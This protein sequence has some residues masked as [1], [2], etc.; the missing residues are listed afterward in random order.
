MSAHSGI[1]GTNGELLFA[2]VHRWWFRH[3]WM[4]CWQPNNQGGCWVRHFPSGV[5]HMLEF[6]APAV[7]DRTG[8]PS[9]RAA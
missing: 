7:G 2:D 3:D 1:T 6:Y 5:T 8:R 4:T 9:G